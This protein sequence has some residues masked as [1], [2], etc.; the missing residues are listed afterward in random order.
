M[1]EV[2]GWDIGGAHVKAA[3]LR[4][5]RVIDAAQWPCPLWMGIDRLDAVL[6]SAGARWPDLPH[7]THAVTM[8]GEMVDLFAHREDGVARLA[9]L[10]AQ[11]LPEPRFF[12]GELMWFAATEAARHWHVVASANWLASTRHVALVCSDDAGLLIDIGSTTTDLIAFGHGRVHSHGRSDAQRLQSGEL[13]Y[14]GVVRTP[15][16]ALAQRVRWRGVHSNV[17]NEFF[18]TTADVYRLTGELDPAHDQ[19][20][21]ADHAPKD[22]AHTHARLAR[23]IGLDGRDAGADEWLAFAR[24]WRARQIDELRSQLARVAAAHALGPASIAVGAGCGA[25]LLPELV[26]TGW[27]VLDYGRDVAAIDA[28]ASPTVAAWARVGAPAVAV[29]SLFE[30]EQR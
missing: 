30:R 6:D 8:T 4:R 25:F 12:G 9:S 3:R 18:A 15:L 19:H 21:S 24:D 28:A 17:M 27:R 2:V 14:Q 10:L 26:P 13:V 22:V 16:C 7:C 23:L 20:P 29:A 1:P 11:R 5:G